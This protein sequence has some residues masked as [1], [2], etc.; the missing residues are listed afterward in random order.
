MKLQIDASTIF[1]ITKGKFKLNRELLIKDLKIKD[2]H[3]TYYIKGLP[4]SP[5]CF[6]SK[7]TIEIVLED[8]KSEYL[9]YFY[10]KDLKKHIYSKTFDQHKIKLNKYRTNK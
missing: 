7:K 5:I 6:V 2:M 10:N 3:N 1:S 9:F 4:P 8:Y